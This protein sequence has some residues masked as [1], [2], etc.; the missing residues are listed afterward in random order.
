MTDFDRA[1]LEWVEHA[2]I[3]E[4]AKTAVLARTAVGVQSYMELFRADA[5]VLPPADL[6]F[7]PAL[8]E[9]V[10]R[11]LRRVE[12]GAPMALGALKPPAVFSGIVAPGAGYSSA[13]VRAA[14][15]SRL[16][17]SRPASQAPSRVATARA[18]TGRAASTAS[19][20]TASTVVGAVS[21]SRA[22]GGTAGAVKAPMAAAAARPSATAASTP[23]PG[24]PRT[25]T[26][27]RPASAGASRP[28]WG[29]RAAAPA[30]PAQ[31]RTPS[32]R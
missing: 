29:S 14:S 11:A 28:A 10:A 30:A 32:G 15:G 25:A 26:G 22:A 1:V 31:I 4:R 9:T 7:D 13:S 2:A 6:R 16:P 5:N 12:E 23:R 21:S 27:S 17:T 24:T 18:A 3:G 8:K 20:R 19:S